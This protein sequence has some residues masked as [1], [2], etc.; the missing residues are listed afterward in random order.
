M[1]SSTVICSRR[2]FW[3]A[4]ITAVSLA[5]AAV[6]AA[7]FFV[8]GAADSRPA[9]TTS[10]TNE[11]ASASGAAPESEQVAA[12]AGT[13]TM[14]DRVAAIDVLLACM[15]QAGLEGVEVRHGEGLRRGGVTFQVKE[16]EDI[17]AANAL[18]RGCVERT[19]SPVE[20]AWAKQQGIL[21]SEET[22]ALH[23]RLEECVAAGGVPDEKYLGGSFEF[24]PNP[25]LRHIQIA[26]AD[27]EKFDQC[28]QREEET[29]GL[30]PPFPI[31]GTIAE[32]HAW[33]MNAE[34]GYA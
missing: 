23:R 14:A 31:P 8:P 9:A 21:T 6:A 22:E 26:R 29:T 28:A 18:Y 24:Y 1:E 27:L 16:A 4:S 32:V 2:R 7:I 10:P 17:P 30:K 25:P 20:Q 3:F 12:R 34:G 15:K 5:G 19:T 11:A 13:V 33:M